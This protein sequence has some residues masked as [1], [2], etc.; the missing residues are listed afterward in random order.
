MSRLLFVLALAVAVQARAQT[1]VCA[2]APSPV[3]LAA[4]QAREVPIDPD[5]G[6]AVVEA[7]PGVH[8]AT[9]GSFNFAV[10]PTGAGTVLIDAPT[11]LGAR[12]VEIARSVSAEPITHVVYTHAHADHIGGAYHLDPTGLTVVASAGAAEE[13]ALV[14]IPSREHVFGTF[15]FGQG[16]VPSPTVVVDESHVL[17][18][19]DVTFEL[20]SLPAAHSHGDLTVYLPESRALVAVDFTWPA[21]IPWIRLG[22]AVNTPGMIAGNRAL[23]DYD[24]D[25]L[26]SGH[27]GI[28]GTRAD[29]ENTVAYLEQLRET[30]VA[31]L[32][33]VSVGDV[34]QEVQTQ[35]GYVLMDAYLNRLTETAAA[36]VLA[37]WRDRLRGS[38]VWTCTH[39]Q[40]MVS[41]LRF[42][43]RAETAF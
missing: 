40:K 28:V 39:A 6:Y 29:V 26:I 42:D 7:A 23:L 27:F 12:L 35:N 37:E 21:S 17:R 2:V 32:R 18:V 16:A 10:V 4:A 5:L 36:P 20:R 43:D 30:S 24:F 11:S 14:N 22:D 31:A 9:D 3:A 13:L 1:D 34:A 8:M 33:S 15:V 38:G 25:A 19:G 41:S